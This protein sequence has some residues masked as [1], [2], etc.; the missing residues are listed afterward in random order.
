LGFGAGRAL[1]TWSSV[2]ARSFAS[3]T[4]APLATS[5]SGTPRPSTNKLRLRPFFSPIRR[6]GPP[7]LDR[8]RSLHHRPIDALPVP[9][10]ALPLVILGQPRSPQ[11]QKKTGPVPLLKMLVDG[12]RAPQFL[13]QRL[14]LTSRTQHI[15]DR[16]EHLSRRH[17]LAPSTRPALVFPARQSLSNWNQGFYLRPKLVRYGPRFYLRHLGP[18]SSPIQERISIVIYG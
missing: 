17:R 14:P 1:T 18:S 3:C 2:A 8:Q 15:H 11:P 4:L 12:A 9:G 16:G 13:R 5:D 6:V 10:N 7:A